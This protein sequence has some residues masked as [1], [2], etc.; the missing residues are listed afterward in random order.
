MTHFGHGGFE[1]VNGTY[2]GYLE[3]T[4]V[5]AVLSRPDFYSFGSASTPEA[6]NAL[7]GEWRQGMHLKH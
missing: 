1:D 4:G 3:R 7:V 2:A 6:L 5:A